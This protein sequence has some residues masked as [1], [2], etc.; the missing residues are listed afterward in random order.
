MRTLFSPSLSHCVPALFALFANIGL[1]SAADTTTPYQEGKG[2]PSNATTSCVL[3]FKPV[4]AGQRLEISNVTCYFG[5]A[6]SS[7][8]VALAAL[9]VFDGRK[10][11]SAQF[12]TPVW[13]ATEPSAAAAAEA[14]T[15]Q[16]F[17]FATAGQN[18]SI[19]IVGT[20]DMTGLQGNCSLS[21]HM[22]AAT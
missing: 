11:I 19:T 9:S 13:V 1:A 14:L 20:S 5:I 22:V 2:C 6:P 15:D 10:N 16:V 4:P 3:N 21:G 17:A 12:L 18:F 7:A 8:R